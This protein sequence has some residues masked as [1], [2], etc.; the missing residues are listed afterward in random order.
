MGW[1]G[2]GGGGGTDQ[3]QHQVSTLIN[4]CYCP[5]FLNH[6]MLIFQYGYFLSC[7]NMFPSNLVQATFQ[8]V[9]SLFSD[10]A[11]TNTKAQHFFKWL[12]ASLS[13]LLF[14]F[15]GNSI[16]Q[17]AS[18]LWNPSPR[19]V[20]PNQSQPHGEHSSM[21]SKMIMELTSRTSPLT[22]L[23]PLTCSYALG[24]EQATAWMSLELLFF[25]PQWVYPLHSSLKSV[26]FGLASNALKLIIAN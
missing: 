23:H 3:E 6:D 9:R 1:G 8:Q 22:W 25:Q 20:W 10:T 17:V 5:T 24:K 14:L 18:T 4:P 13:L 26:E 11:L 19:W 15:P 21:E 16:E 12:I 7:S 2:G